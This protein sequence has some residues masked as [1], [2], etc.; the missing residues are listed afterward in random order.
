[1]VFVYRGSIQ[2]V[3]HAACV[4]L[5]AFVLAGCDK[6]A[7]APTVPPPA[8]TVAYPVEKEVIE[9][10]TYTGYIEAPES[11]N[12][13]ARVSGLIMSTPFNEGAIIKKGDV[14]FNIDVRPFKADLDVKLADQQKAQA[15]S[16]IAETNF[17]R[18]EEAI[19]AHAVSQQDYDNA[20]AARDQANAELASAKAAVEL[21]RLN[22]EWCQV[23]SP[24]DGRVSNKLVT[25]GNLVNGGAGQATLLT[26]IQ[27]V[28]PIYCYV[29]VDEHSVLKYQKLSVEKKRVS[30]RDSQIPCFLELAN[31]TG[32]PHAG[33]VDFV[34]N[35][36]DPSTGTIRARGVFPNA[37][38]QLTPGFFASM[39]S[40]RQRPIQGT[41]RAG[42][43]DRHRPEPAQCADR[44]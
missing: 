26:T 12:V 19:K 33:V 20:K 41:A 29:D 1:M 35:H 8:V 44:E 3:R 4:L 21:S 2:F 10:D 13:M 7:A 22:V 15:Q 42:H 39:R 17:E 14:L 40:S 28:T 27:S 18:E 11:V 16:E 36:V 31:E 34:D 37:N 30:A 24:I 25:V 32:F 43:R 38:G 6:Q 5:A 9:W 23:T